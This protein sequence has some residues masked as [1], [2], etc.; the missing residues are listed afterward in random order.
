MFFED[1]LGGLTPGQTT[2]IN[3]ALEEEQQRKLDML[4]QRLEA[5][6]PNEQPVYS[7]EALSLTKRRPT[8][9]AP[10]GPGFFEDVGNQAAAKLYTDTIMGSMM[11]QSQPALPTPA[12]PG[13]FEDVFGQ[14]ANSMP[15]PSALPPIDLPGMGRNEQGPLAPGQH[16]GDFTLGNHGVR[17]WNGDNAGPAPLMLPEPGAGYTA[18]NVNTGE[19]TPSSYPTDAL[20]G[21]RTAIVDPYTNPVVWQQDRMLD[22]EQAFRREMAQ[23]ANQT[24]IDEANIQA[25]GRIGAADARGK[26]IEDVKRVY[27]DPLLP[28]SVKVAQINKRDD[29]DPV[30]RNRVVLDLVTSKVNPTTKGRDAIPHTDAKGQSQL[31]AVLTKIPNTISPEEVI[32]FLDEW[33]GIPKESIL[34]RVADIKMRGGIEQLDP[35]QKKEYDQLV[36]LG[37]MPELPKKKPVSS[38]T[39]RSV[40]FGGGS[41]FGFGR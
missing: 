19:M 16:R 25:N 9:V 41:I 37:I 21:Q 5:P 26:K 23:L 18:K 33:R 13:F 22:K 20:F 15:A 8:M 6:I 3:D 12:V 28:D 32:S 10:A 7:P 27:A 2:M 38:E 4:Q 35:Q 34:K 36:R 39:M 30:D 24:R 40:S 31:D 1:F 29:L 11:P 14:A 17:I